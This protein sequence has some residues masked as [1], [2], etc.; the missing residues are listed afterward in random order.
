MNSLRWHQHALVNRLQTLVLLAVMAAFMALLGW[1]LGGADG[2][3]LLIAV[4]LG[5]F[6]FSPTITPRLVMRLYRAEP[7]SPSQAPRLYQVL[8]ELAQRGGLPATPVLYHLPSDMVNAFAVGHPGQA[9]IAVTD[10]LL[11]NLNLREVSAVLAHEV[12][13]VRSNDM[14]V[15]GLADT[16]SR[17]TSSLSLFGQLLLLLNLPLLLLGAVTINWLAIGLLIMAPTMSALAQLGLSRTREYDADLNAA[18]L[19]GDPESLAQALMKIEQIQGGWLERIFLPGRRLP[20]PSMLRTH[21]PTEERVRRLR[22]LQLSDSASLRF[23]LDPREAALRQNLSLRSVKRGPRW[24][25]SGLW[26]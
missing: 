23:D 24:H 4:A 8:A 5:I 7:L 11:R 20:E 22:S 25:M 1:L 12:S 16:F 21:P 26:H 2:L 10:G 3:I 18:R 17:L 14:Q 19:T 6:L 15:M 13:H 9:G